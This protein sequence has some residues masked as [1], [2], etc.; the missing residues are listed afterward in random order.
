MLYKFSNT[1]LNFTKLFALSIATFTLLTSAS[2]AQAQNPDQVQSQTKDQT[3]LPPDVAFSNVTGDV[4]IPNFSYAGYGYG[5]E[6]IPD[7]KGA[8]ILI[9]ED[10]NITPDDDKDDSEAFLKLLDKAN[11]MSGDIV[12]Q[13]PKGKIEI[14]EIIPI[15]RSNIV[16]RGMGD[17]KGGT[18]IHMP[19]PLSMIDTK[20]KFD[21]INEY[22]TRLK[23]IQ[24]EPDR[25]VELQFSDYSWTGGFFWIG[26]KDYRAAAYLE[27]LD[28]PDTILSEALT[29]NRGDRRLEVENGAKLEKG[30]DVELVWFSRDGAEGGIIQSLY[31]NTDLKVGSHH[32]TFPDRGLVRQKTQISE[33]QDNVVTLADPLLHPVSEDVP[34]SLVDWSPLHKIGFEDIAFTFPEGVSFGHHLEQGFNAIYFAG[35]MHSWVRDITVHNAD[36]GILSYGSA[37]LT[38]DNVTT[39]GMREAHYSIHAGNVHNVLV[40]D[41]SVQNRV[42]HALT[43]NTQSTKTVFLRSEVFQQP[44]LDQHAGSNHQNLFDQTIFHLDANE[45]NGKPSYPVWDGSGAG[46]WQ[47][48]HG[49][50][51]TTYNPE[52]RV[53]S[54]A[55]RNQTVIAEGTAEGPDARII[56]I[57]GNRPISINY[58]PRPAEALIG[59]EP[60]V[61]SLYEWQLKQRKIELGLPMKK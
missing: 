6:D 22:L 48:G 9:A 38:L 5:L 32:W 42:R 27:E 45:T 54:G 17:G 10:F 43:V 47:P 19:R 35:A 57:W 41:L 55:S 56:G 24:R 3:N 51:S 16:F 20:G 34:A 1:S 8:R 33:I 7:F 23:K 39:T 29:G 15:T 60:E 49:R 58:R 37:N 40:S 4:F 46:Y 12:I 53:K 44:T 50:F 21:E 31:G 2:C 14:S 13:L 28:R 52:L 30:D 36:S 61:K 11:S 18:E 26:P 59:V 25:N